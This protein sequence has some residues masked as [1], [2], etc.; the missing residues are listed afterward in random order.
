MS[1]KVVTLG[2]WSPLTTQTV[3]FAYTLFLGLL[4]IELGF[5]GQNGAHLEQP[6]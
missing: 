5:G 6:P 3:T 2:D 1:Y 4:F